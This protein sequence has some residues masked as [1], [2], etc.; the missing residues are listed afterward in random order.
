MKRLLRPFLNAAR[1]PDELRRLLTLLEDVP[2]PPRREIRAELRRIDLRSADCWLGAALTVVPPMATFG[3]VPAIFHPQAVAP[4][5][6]PV[7]MVFALVASAALG[8]ASVLP[9]VTL[10]RRAS[11][12]HLGQI[13]RRRGICVECGYDLRATPERCPECGTIPTR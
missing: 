9:G 10:L 6:P 11:A 7:P 3:L 4:F 2:D 1:V 12:R 13:L 5:H 8:V